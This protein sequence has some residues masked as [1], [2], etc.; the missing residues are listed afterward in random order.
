MAKKMPVSIIS[1][2]GA[3]SNS[4]DAVVQQC[5]VDVGLVPVLGQDWFIGE[6]GVKVIT[7][8][9][10][11][12][13]KERIDE[14]AARGGEG[15]RAL[16]VA[17]KSSGAVLAWNTFRFHFPTI[18]KEFSRCA[19]VLVDPHGAV[20]LDHKP[21]PY[22]AR[23]DLTWPPDWSKDTKIFRVYNIYQHKHPR[24]TAEGITGASFP[25]AFENKEITEAGVHHMNIAERRQTRSMI[26]RALKFAMKG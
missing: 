13:I 15:E 6:G 21:G 25:G 4:I 26:T 14:L 17:G 22:C 23:R 10:A 1:M 11:K 24:P 9:D 2:G 5:A 3:F 7:K 12:R 19:V 8:R 20:T 16:L 18:I